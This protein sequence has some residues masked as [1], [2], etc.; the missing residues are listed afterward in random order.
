VAA[1]VVLAAGAGA[2]A[3][4]S[5]LHHGTS[6]TPPPGPAA[7]GTT[8]S[9]PTSPSTT[10][11]QTTPPAT[12]PATTPTPSSS[13]PASTVTLSQA[14]KASPTATAVQSLF[15]R[16]FN[17]INTRNYSEY[18][19]T[20][21]PTM[22]AHSTQSQFDSGYKSTTDSREVINSITDNGGGSM[23]ANVSFSSTQDPSDSVD[24]SSCNNWTL[25]LP[26]VPKGSGYVL[27]PPPSG[28]AT[29]T[30]C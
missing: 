23:T 29:Y 27:S 12:T 17:A 2:F 30:D 3:L 5:S 14:A 20:L 6:S 26:L 18:T 24:K 4:V 8:T 19:G 22:Q 10:P 9:A 16:Y 11:A 28:Y 25:N 21:N 13:G 1:V 7:L 15:N